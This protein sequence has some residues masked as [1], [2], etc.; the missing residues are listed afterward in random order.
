VGKP[1]K[2]ID[3]MLAR[4]A[5]YY[6]AQK[7]P[8]VEFTPEYQIGDVRADAYMEV[9]RNGFNFPFFVEVQLSP[10]FR[11]EKYERLY[12]SGV[13]LDKWPEFPWVIVVID[14]SLRLKE[15]NVKYNLFPLKGGDLDILL[16]EA[17]HNC[18][19]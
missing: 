5:F 6:Q 1:P 13:W 4:V 16:S 17:E 11:Q 19:F 9:W 10:Y 14:I 3:H 15:G 2:E 7:Y 18:I 8:L 12:T